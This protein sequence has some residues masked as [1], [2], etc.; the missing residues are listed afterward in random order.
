M[1]TNKDYFY[2]ELEDSIIVNSILEDFKQRQ[3]ERKPYEL[4]WELNMNFYLG[5]QN[6][7]IS[8]IGEVGECEKHFYWEN[9]DVYN[10]IAPVIES[11]LAKLNKVKPNLSVNP[12]S[13]S[14]Q[15]I[16]SSKLAKSIL[17][18]TLD[19]NNFQNLIST[20]THWSEITGTSFYK[21]TWEDDLGDIVGEIDSKQIKNGDIKISVCS[22]FEI[23]PDSNTCVDVNDCLSII[24]ARAVPISYIN[25]T[26]NTSLSGEDVD[27]FEIN[28]N[29]FSSNILGHNNTT[30]I[31][32][33]KKS[34]HALLIERYEKP[35]KTNPNGKLTIICQNKL[36]YDGA[37]PYEVSRNK[38]RGYPFVKQVSIKQLACFWGISVIE[39]CIPIQKAYNAIKNKKHEY[40]SRLTSGVLTV[41]DGSVDVDNLETEGLAPG[42]ILIYR[43]G[44]TAPQFLSPGTIPSELENEESK[45][46]TE[47]NNMCCISDL[48]TNSTVPSS[49]SSGS[50]L[51]LLI[52]QD[53]SRLSLVAEHIRFS[54]KDIG[55]IIIRLYKQFADKIRLNKFVDTNGNLEIYYWTKN[56][57]T[58]DDIC[59]ETK[60]ELEESSIQT[61][62]TLI[63]LMDKGLFN[64]SNGEISHTTKTKLLD[65]LGFKNFQIPEDLNTI[66]K[67]R[68]QNENLKLEEL[69]EPLEIDNHQI[70][71]EEH[72]KFI[73]SDFKH[74]I[75]ND[76][77]SKLLNHI[78]EHKE[79]L[80][81]I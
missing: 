14:E 2:S 65:M 7:Y 67:N 24:E 44:S 46:L 78:K 55:T 17:K 57:L 27:V 19:N 69:N 50:A 11:R 43:N 12:T 49:V 54:I 8:N 3:L 1:T 28:N 77:K 38:T 56:D 39:R 36:L 34:D 22:P 15:D 59:F 29:S 81:K 37:L 42:K 35:N 68:A 53:E 20:A 76:F 41:E 52:E 13:S 9:Q 73:I 31:I 60:N 23:Y 72:I 21:I 70:H 25:N 66:H 40:I 6:T 26:W 30:K 62:E 16:H 63:S 74:Q 80:N 10:H 51:T 75:D 71:I 79:F 5:N 32:H 61:K 18:S 58:S 47:L 64:E 33:S 45:L 48:T 4:A